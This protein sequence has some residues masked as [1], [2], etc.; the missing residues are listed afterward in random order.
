MI[1]KFRIQRPKAVETGLARD[2]AGDVRTRRKTLTL[3][4]YWLSGVIAVALL[5]LLAVGAGVLAWTQKEADNNQR[6]R[7]AF[8]GMVV[9]ALEVRVASLQ[10]RLRELG[11]DPRLRATLQANDQDVLRSE[12]ESL[13][14]LIPDTKQVHLLALGIDKRE[15]PWAKSLSYAG[16]D[17][18]E[19]TKRRR[20][21]TRLEV[22]RPGSPEEHLAIAAPVFDV[23][24]KD[25]LGALYLSLSTE[26]LPSVADA[27]GE[28]GRL[29]YQQVVGKQVVNL[30]VGGG[31]AP[32]SGPPDYEMPVAGTSLRVVAWASS[33]AAPDAGL[34]VGAVVVYL[35][36]MA[37]VVVAMWLP[38][39]SLRRALAADLDGMV[40]VVED[41]VKGRPVPLPICRLAETWPLIDTL[42]R[43]MHRRQKAFRAASR[44]GPEEISAD[45]EP[46][47][48]KSPRADKERVESTPGAA[49]DV[50]SP[51]GTLAE[52]R[53]Q[54][55]TVPDH[56]FR[57]HDI[58]GIVDLDLSPD[59]VRSIGRAIGTEAQ[60]AGD[61]TV[62]V[63]RD[64]RPSG[65]ALS[66]ALI[67]GLRESGRDVL[68][69]GVVPTPLV[70][71]GTRYQG[72]TSGVMVT[73]SLN[74]D[75]YNGL[76]VVVGGNTLD[77]Q[78]IKGLRQRVLAGSFSQGAGDYQVGDLANDYV[79]HVEKDVAIARTLK[80]VIDCGNAATAVVAPR[81]Y[82]ALGCDLVELD[83]DLDGSIASG[84]IPDPSNPGCMGFLRDAV[85]SQGADLGLAFD[86]A[87]D[88]LGVVDS[89]GKIIWPDRVLMLLAA[90]VLSR[91][92][93]TD[94]VIDAE[95]SHHLAA[96]ILRHGGHPVRVK[97]G[98]APLKAK[99]RETGAL[100]AGDW[101]GHIVFRERWFGFDDA[102]YSG[103]R[104]L[105][106]LA[107][108]PRS[109][110]EIFAELPAS[111]GTPELF[112]PLPEG[113]ADTTMATLIDQVRQ[114]GG[115]HLSMEDG[116][117]VESG[118]GWGLVRASSSRPALVFRFE[119]EDET[120]LSQIQDLFRGFM[121]QA[122]P[123]LRLPF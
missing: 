76:K 27:S 18:I 62:I 61:Q 63:G 66:K 123:E 22:H 98:H 28:W 53:Q 58:R 110:A 49:E 25:L 32:P 80:V 67:A 111:V 119:A 23:Q 20:S 14:R 3:T 116:L 41:T 57:P 94:V 54:R 71:F 86:R 102:L 114:L 89:S 84:R 112:V 122:A 13:A 8:S 81:L 106:T 115:L 29:G 43:L 60:E 72:E 9:A 30:H 117:R 92:P 99:L 16:Q 101:C 51:E 5:I 31:A 50:A 15:K 35:A 73:G 37:L 1:G 6:V 74:P 100:L 4:T 46:Q 12:E 47:N 75:R 85:V 82:R 65:A 79:S 91:H 45:S 121:E 39:R 90:D 64:T 95:S 42:T 24:G 113:V 59:L 103:A 68:D 2:K 93:G 38:L 11:T 40:A 48:D 70:Y 77:G 10:T 108:D 78:R 88:R 55:K 52:P 36:L 21:V 33:D 69:L 96:E 34:L 44:V 17:L 83:C 118:Q 19:Q 97:T 105:E 7:K 26:L 120:G 56:I 107:L 87:G 109:S 104:L